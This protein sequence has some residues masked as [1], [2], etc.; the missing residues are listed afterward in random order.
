MQNFVII[1]SCFSA[2][3]LPIVEAHPYWENDTPM[4]ILV[5][6]AVV[7]FCNKHGRGDF[8][9]TVKPIDL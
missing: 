5:E 7:A 2:D 4:Q 3:E 6:T 1:I 9:V 8:T